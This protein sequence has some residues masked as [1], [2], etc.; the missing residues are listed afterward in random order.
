[1]RYSTGTVC[2]A[3]GRV[4]GR[5]NA[6]RRVRTRSRAGM[7]PARST[8][9]ASAAGGGPS[10]AEAKACWR[11]RA[12]ASGCCGRLIVSGLDSD[13]PPAATRSTP[14]SPPATAVQGSQT[15]TS[16]VAKS[17]SALLAA[18]STAR[19]GW[20]DSASS[21]KKWRP[22]MSSTRAR[23]RGGTIAS[24]S[25]SIASASGVRMRA[26]MTPPMSA[27]P[28]TT[29][30]ARPGSTRSACRCTSRSSCEISTSTV[31]ASAP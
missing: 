31:V 11:S 29:T 27:I 18:V 5:R 8:T 22:P 20:L 6:G 25:L 19:S 26:L 7:P 2:R 30:S 10:S 23:L 16:C 3:R 17:A 12:A 15:M 14:A 9:S 28:A 1:M 21:R 24:R 13:A 4:A